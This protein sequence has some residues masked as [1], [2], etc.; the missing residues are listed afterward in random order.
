VI[1]SDT[2]SYVSNQDGAGQ[3]ADDAPYLV[4]GMEA[5]RPLAPAARFSLAA[6]D[7][8]VIGRGPERTNK[9]FREGGQGYMRISLPDVWMS[10]EHARFVNDL[11]G[12]R[13]EDCGSKN[14][15][16]LNGVRSTGG[17]LRH[18]DLVETG[19]TLFLFRSEGAPGIKEPADVDRA[20]FANVPAA[21][22]TLSPTLRRDFELLPKIASSGV[23]MLV[24]GETGTGKEVIARTIHDLS[25]RRG[26]FTAVN[27]GALPP[28]LIESEL[29]GAKK[30]AF[31]GAT[32]DRPGL[33]RAA[34]GGTLFLDEI[35]ELPE[36]SQAALLRVLQEREVVPVG[37]TQPIKVDI[38]V[39]AATHQDLAGRVQAGKFRKDLYSRLIGYQLDLPPLRERREDIGLLVAE[40]LPRVAGDRAP[41]IKFHRAAARALFS[42]DWPLNI[43]ELEH[44]L[45]SAVA[46]AED[47]MIQ[48]E[49]LPASVRNRE[50]TMTE[51]DRPRLSAEDEALREQLVDLLNEHDGNVSAVARVLKKERVQI[52]RWCRRLAI[53]LDGYR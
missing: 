50:P 49:H 31:S 23:P 15:T 48:L 32:E 37:G 51:K 8:V 33:V 21:L 22:V 18:G 20:D 13:L 9:R 3:S 27:C 6:V 53:D 14:G 16:Y 19:S 30:G 12:W 38:R 47:G 2:I 44:A 17:R 36:A 43:R 4:L 11:G 25:G 40:L 42:F 34:D 52:R 7:V 41:D 39:L 26:P 28:T 24:L 45:G 35:A 29:F 46:L 10:S 1:D 5:S